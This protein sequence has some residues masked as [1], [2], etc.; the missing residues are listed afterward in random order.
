MMDEPLVSVICLCYN[1]EQFVRETI[2]SVLNQSYKNMELIVV[3]DAST[4]QSVKIIHDTIQKHPA[5]QFM[6]LDE[7]VGNCRAFNKGL[8]LARGKYIIDLA[9]DDILLP[10]RIAKGVKA[11]AE[12]GSSYGVNFSD[13]EWISEAGAHLYF[14]S[15]R[16]PHATIPQGNIYKNLIERFFICSPTVMFSREVIES[17]GGYDETLSY[18]DF[19]FWIRSSRNFLYC[20]TP[21]VLVKKRVVHKSLSDKQFKFFSPHSLTTLQ[22]CKKI[23]TLNKSMDEKRALAKRI[24]YEF[25]LNLRLLNFP[26]ALQFLKLGLRNRKG[27]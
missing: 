4:D 15:E 2:G 27:K 11:L 20:Y 10:D 6:G 24:R 16:F 8:L 26:V 14:H 18:E 19:D 1:Q 25:L 5:I 17:L 13:A 12:A 21:E 3:D 9:A 7:N 23:L 22:V